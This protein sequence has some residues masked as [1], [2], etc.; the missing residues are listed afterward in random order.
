MASVRFI[1][2]PDQGDA[3][4]VVL[5]VE[6]HEQL[7]VIDI[8]ST[9]IDAVRFPTARRKLPRVGVTD[10]LG[11]TYRGKG[12]EHYGSGWSGSAPVAHYPMEFRGP[13]PPDARYLRISFGTMIGKNRGVVVM[14]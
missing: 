6:L 7:V 9:L 12:L 4:I 3:E 14:L 1:P 10:D 5:G 2:G 8:A 11:T 13:V